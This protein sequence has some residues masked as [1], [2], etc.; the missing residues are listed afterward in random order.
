MT[1]ILIAIIAGAF[2]GISAVL[3]LFWWAG[4]IERKRR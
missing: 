4:H 2:G 1:N 3:G